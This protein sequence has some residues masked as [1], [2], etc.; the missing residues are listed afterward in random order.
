M[1]AVESAR[2][3]A[4]DGPC[5]LASFNDLPAT[6]CPAWLEDFASDRADTV[7][8]DEPLAWTQAERLVDGQPLYVPFD[9]VSLDCVRPWDRRFD[10]TS[11]GLGARLDDAGAALKGLLEVLEQDATAAWRSQPLHLRAL[12]AVDRRSIPYAWF[13]EIV[14]RMAGAGIRLS[15]HRLPTVIGLPALHAEVFARSA[16]GPSARANGWACAPRAEDALRG[17]VLEA[18]QCRLT[19]I[20]GARDDILYGPRRGLR[21]GEACALPPHL[22]ALPWS[23]LVDEGMDSSAAT[24]W[25]IADELARAGYPDA[26]VVNLSAPADQV[27]VVKVFAPGLAAN[28]RARRPAIRKAAA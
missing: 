13:G 25:R 28:F 15:I 3:E 21:A 1:E 11:N 6:Q 27:R 18:L 23:A 17:A 26:A 10:H 5:R 14:E 20:A 7:R 19:A 4:F 2:A 8:A 16:P 9:A 22:R 12:E 24:P